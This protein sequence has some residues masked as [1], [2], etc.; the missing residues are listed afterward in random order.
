VRSRAFA[1]AAASRALVGQRDGAITDLTAYADH[2]LR[3]GATSAD[4]LA[5][6]RVIAQL[7]AGARFSSFAELEALGIRR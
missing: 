3:D 4:G 7:R 5:R 2:L 6:R 1:T